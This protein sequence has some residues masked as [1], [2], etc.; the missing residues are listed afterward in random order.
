MVSE[1]L[2]SLLLISS[3]CAVGLAIVAIEYMEGLSVRE[4]ALMKYGVYL[5]LASSSIL[6][7]L[8]LE[9]RAEEM[10]LILMPV[11]ALVGAGIFMLGA[12]AVAKAMQRAR[13]I[14]GALAFGIQVCVVAFL[15][16]TSLL[17]P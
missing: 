11:F 2:L 4:A 10:F 17:L 6:A 12:I 9:Y 5:Q 8:H 13:V 1:L 3:V 15:T 16:I 14:F 7:G